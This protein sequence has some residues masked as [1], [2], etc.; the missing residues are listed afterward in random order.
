MSVVFHSSSPPQQKKTKAKGRKRKTKAKPK[1]PVDD[2][3]IS[4]KMENQFKSPWWERERFVKR[5]TNWMWRLRPFLMKK[6]EAQC[7]SCQMSGRCHR[8]PLNERITAKVA[9]GKE[10][11]DYKSM[12]KAIL[13]DDE[14]YDW[15][16]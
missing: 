2:R 4:A 16:F 7:N 9:A 8:I 14:P 5:R 15:G 12:W 11:P 1:K 6:N 3:T 10:C 13:G